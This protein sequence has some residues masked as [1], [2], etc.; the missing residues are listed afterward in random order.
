MKKR[1]SAFLK[2]LRML[3]VTRGNSQSDN[4]IEIL[5]MTI[6]LFVR[7][8]P[9]GSLLSRD[10]SSVLNILKLSSYKSETGDMGLSVLNGAQWFRIAKNRDVSA[11]PLA[12]GKENY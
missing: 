7:A 5:I 1:A 9:L 10:Y 3:N 2:T 8:W 12:R 4:I 11:W 6:K